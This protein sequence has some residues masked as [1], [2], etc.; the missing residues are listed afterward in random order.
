VNTPLGGIQVGD[1]ITAFQFDNRLLFIVCVDLNGLD[2]KNGAL[3]SR[4]DGALKGAKKERR[5]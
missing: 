3:S 1:Q 2:D 5:A 4:G